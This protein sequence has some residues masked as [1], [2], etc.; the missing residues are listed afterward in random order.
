MGRDY[1]RL[2]FAQSYLQQANFQ[3]ATLTQANFSKVLG[4]VYSVGFSPSGDR[5]AIGDSKGVVQVWDSSTGQVLLFCTGHQN[6]V[7]SVVFSPDGHT[8]AS[9]SD[10]HTVKLWSSGTGECV[11]TLAGHQNAVNSVVF[12]PD[13]HTLAIR[14]C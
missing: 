10:D 1:T 13:G 8:L 2:D 9:G 3:G 11:R 12:S 4:S 5:I 6:A 14:Q 7:R